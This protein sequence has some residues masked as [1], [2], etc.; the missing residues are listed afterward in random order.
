MAW[1]FIL[2]CLYDGDVET[3]D[4]ASLPFPLSPFFATF[5]CLGNLNVADYLVAEKCLRYECI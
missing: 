3:C 1:L 4:S 2:V 5:T